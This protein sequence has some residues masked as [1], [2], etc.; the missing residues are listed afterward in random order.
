MQSGSRMI[1]LIRFLTEE[2]EQLP[3]VVKRFSLRALLLLL[4]WYIGYQCIIK[5]DARIDNS[6][7]RVTTQAI[8]YSLNKY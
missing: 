8:T 3:I 5:P 6:L 4:F 1:P 2:W 7:T